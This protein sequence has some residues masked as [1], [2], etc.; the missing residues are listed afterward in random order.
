MRSKSSQISLDHNGSPW[1]PHVGSTGH[2]IC[3]HPMGW[4]S[5]GTGLSAHTKIFKKKKKYQHFGLKPSVEWPGPPRDRLFG[6]RGQGG[7]A[8]VRGQGGPPVLLKGH[9]GR[10]NRVFSAYFGVSDPYMTHLGT[11]ENFDFCPFL[12]YFGLYRAPLCTVL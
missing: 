5:A 11:F 1:Q 9:P 7:R 10:R 2:I 12:A 8:S 4:W 6:R 3:S